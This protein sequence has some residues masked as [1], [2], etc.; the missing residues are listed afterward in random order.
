MGSRVEGKRKR[1]SKKVAVTSKFNG[2]RKLS[3]MGKKVKKGK[4]G[5]NTDFKTRSYVLKKLQIS[6]KDFRRLCIL[7]GIYP[8]VP[9]KA[10]IKG[11]DKIY[12]DIKDITYLSHEPLLAKFREFKTFMKKIRKAA[13]RNQISEARRKDRLKP[14]MQLDHLVK[15]PFVCIASLRRQNHG[16]AYVHMCG[17]CP[18][19][20]ILRCQV[21]NSPKGICI[22]ER[23]L[24]PGRGDGRGNHMVGTPP[25]HTDCASRG[26]SESDDDV[27]GVL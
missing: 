16:R 3:R 8:R 9:S 1:K 27:L 20:A 26:R 17:P 18:S 11:A 22:S 7:K 19:V 12:Y 23:R 25:V 13:G 14:V 10:P 15:E 2:K 21:E 5:P 6:L 24:L 4:M